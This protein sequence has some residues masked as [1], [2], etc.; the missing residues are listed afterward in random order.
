MRKYRRV[1]PPPR[2]SGIPAILFALGF[3]LFFLVK[4]GPALIRQGYWWFVAL[5]CLIPILVI[6]GGVL[7]LLGKNKGP[8]RRKDGTVVYK[9]PGYDLA[10]VVIGGAFLVIGLKWMVESIQ[11]GNNGWIGGLLWMLLPGIFFYRGMKSFYKALKK[12]RN[13]H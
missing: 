12:R 8:Q 6:Y 2:L 5:W 3:M 11:A 13:R 10:S 7:T 4:A 9:S 1:G